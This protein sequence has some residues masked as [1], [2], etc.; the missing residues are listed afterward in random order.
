M[1]KKELNYSQ[2]II[3]IE[4]ILEKIETEELDVD[5][6]SEKVK[7]ISELIKY[8]KEKLHSTDNEIQKI[9]DQIDEN[10]D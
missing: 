7:R 10:E 2:A 5:L 4:E 9:L 6:L 1:A 8:C 3:E